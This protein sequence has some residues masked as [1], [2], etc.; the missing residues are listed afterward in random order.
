MSSPDLAISVSVA[1]ADVPYYIASTIYNTITNV[2][3]AVTES[4]YFIRSIFAYPFSGPSDLQ[5]LET[6]EDG[7]ELTSKFFLWLG[8]SPNSADGEGNTALHIASKQGHLNILYLL[9]EQEDIDLLQQNQNGIT[10]LEVAV[11]AEQTESANFLANL[12]RIDLNDV[13]ANGSTLLHRVA[14]RG[15]LKNARFLAHHADVEVTK[16]DANSFQAIE[17]AL[18]NG[19]QGVSGVLARHQDADLNGEHQSSGTFLHKAALINS[20][21]MIRFFVNQRRIDLNILNQDEL[22]P[23]ELAVYSKN[24]EAAEALADAS[25][26]LDA[27][28][29]DTGSALIHRAA[30]D[31]SEEALEMLR[32]LVARRDVDLNRR[33]QEG[34]T[35]LET[36]VF[37]ENIEAIKLL[38]TTDGVSLNLRNEHGQTLLHREAFRGNLETIEVLVEAPGLELNLQDRDGKT[39]LH[40]AVLQQKLKVY[41]FLRN[42]IGVD[43]TVLDRQRR[44]AQDIFDQTYDE[45]EL[46]L[47]FQFD[48]FRTDMSNMQAQIQTTV[49]N[50]AGRR[51]HPVREA[52]PPPLTRAA[53]RRAPV[54][55]MVP[56]PP[57]RTPRSAPNSATTNGRRMSAH[58]QMLLANGSLKSKKA[59]EFGGSM[60][61]SNTFPQL[62]PFP[63]PYSSEHNGY[64]GFDEKRDD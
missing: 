39:A 14:K 47:K 21:A 16:K 24:L 30:E 35:P 44:T 3:W 1:I 7:Y 4:F 11:T 40:L 33:N 50:I 62:H 45:N 59:H 29:A 32:F 28:I 53:R 15:D 63:H 38:T 56:P 52:V 6:V 12:E 25:D 64:N 60:A 49:G 34:L 26:D 18:I 17:L 20:V 37:H 58:A 19:H 42:R 10:A 23:L 57:A 36:A 9:A 5:F 8:V 61:H 27:F 2:I 55:E 43:D 31:D 48:R 41:R 22:T 54:R 13:D 51:R 46:Q